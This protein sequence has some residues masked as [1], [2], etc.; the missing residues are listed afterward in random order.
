MDI[1][2]YT[3]RHNLYATVHSLLKIQLLKKKQRKTLAKFSSKYY[4]FR[5]VALVQLDRIKQ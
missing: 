1:E 3:L 5:L 4:S 2:I